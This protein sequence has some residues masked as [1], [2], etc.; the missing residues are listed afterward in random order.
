M[1]AAGVLLYGGPAVGKDTVTTALSG[2]DSRFRLFQRL[3]AGPGRTAGYRMADLEEIARLRQAGEVLWEN[4]R[5]SAVYVV[6]RPELKRVLADGYFPVVHLGQQ[7]A[8]EAI[9]AAAPTVRWA[10]VELW[11]PRPIAAAR[12]EARGTGDTADRL[13]AWAETGHLRHPDLFIDTSLVSAVDAAEQ[14]RQKVAT[15]ASPSSSRR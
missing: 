10:V 9:Q 13:R 15:W 1:T 11:C 4:E 7:A 12:I 2:L 6:D 14:I 5:Y 3:K 8:V